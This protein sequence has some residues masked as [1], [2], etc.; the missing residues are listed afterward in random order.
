[1]RSI[2]SVHGRV[3]SL[4]VLTLG[5][6]TIFC[7][8]ALSHAEVIYT[9]MSV[10]IVNKGTYNYDFNGDGVT[11]LTFALNLQQNSCGYAITAVETPGHDSGAEGK[12]PTPLQTGDQIGPNQQ[13]F[14]GPHT[15]ATLTYNCG[16]WSYSGPWPRGQVRYLGVSFL[17]DGETHYAWA[18]V[19]FD[20]ILTFGPPKLV[21]KLTGFAYETVPGMPIN[22]GQ[23]K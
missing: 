17:I 15:I 20:V 19:E 7:S 9:S 16:H 14:A 8:A 22:A 2:E 4:V 23:T 13:L 18:S 5:M 11:D 1:M 12:P 6:A 10:H 21:A 3:K